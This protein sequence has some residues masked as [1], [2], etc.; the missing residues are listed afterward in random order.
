MFTAFV[1][2]N[3]NLVAEFGHVL[4]LFVRLTDS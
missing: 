2:N 4:I 3:D 1:V